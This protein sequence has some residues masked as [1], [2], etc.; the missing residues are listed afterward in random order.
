RLPDRPSHPRG[1]AAGHGDRHPRPDGTGWHRLPAARAGGIR[2]RARLNCGGAAPHPWA[3]HPPQSPTPRLPRLP[4]ADSRTCYAGLMRTRLADPWVR[5]GGRMYE[6]KSAVVGAGFCGLGVAAAL[7]RRRI[8]FDVL[9]ADDQI[10]GN[11]YRGV[12]ESLHIASSRR[13]TEF[14]DDPMPEDYP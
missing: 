12:Y 10:G 3:G 14:P 4:S 7:K 9:E 5:S 2:P 1:A 13:I 6:E 11:W 8:P